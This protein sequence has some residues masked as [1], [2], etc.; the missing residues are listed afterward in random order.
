MNDTFESM[1]KKGNFDMSQLGKFGISVTSE[2]E[3]RLLSDTNN[4][5]LGEHGNDYFPDMS[6]NAELLSGSGGKKSRGGVG[7][8]T[9]ASRQGQTRGQQR[10]AA[11]AL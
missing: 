1:R 8:A 7:A 6:E 4:R 9:D 11:A 2:E 3:Q 10:A 5:E